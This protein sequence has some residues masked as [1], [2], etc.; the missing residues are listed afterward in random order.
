MTGHAY[1]TKLFLNKPFFVCILQVAMSRFDTDK[2]IDY[3]KLEHNLKTV[4]QR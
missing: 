4:K 2:Y 1:D 3:D